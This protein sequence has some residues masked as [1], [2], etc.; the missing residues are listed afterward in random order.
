[1]NEAVIGKQLTGLLDFG[2]SSHPARPVG[3]RRSKS[4]NER[5]TIR[6]HL[7]MLSYPVNRRAQAFSTF[8]SSGE[9]TFSRYLQADI[10]T[11]PK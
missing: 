1:M 2:D 7:Q 10:I 5:Q 3:L 6:F 11:A 8:A 9:A 4:F